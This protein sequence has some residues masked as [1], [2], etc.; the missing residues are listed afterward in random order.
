VLSS[1]EERVGMIFFH[2]R[3]A[4]VVTDINIVKIERRLIGSKKHASSYHFKNSNANI[5]V[6]I[7]LI[8]IYHLFTAVPGFTNF[9]YSVMIISI[10]PT[11]MVFNTFIHTFMLDVL[12]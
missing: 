7:I 4:T 3:Y 9:H 8:L 5:L 11:E 6:F 10:I 12:R 2:I 1:E